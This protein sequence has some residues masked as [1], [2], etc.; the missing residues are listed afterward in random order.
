MIIQLDNPSI[1]EDVRAW[2]QQQQ[3]ARLHRLRVRWNSVNRG[4]AE[5]RNQ[6]LDEAAGC[7]FAVFFDDDVCPQ[8]GCLD[9]YVEAFKQYPDEAGYAGPTFLPRQPHRLLP[10]S[11]HMSDVSF[12]WDAPVIQASSEN[13]YVPWAVTANVAFKYTS[14]RFRAGFFP[15][16][17]EQNCA[18]CRTS[19]GQKDC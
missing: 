9:A 2:L 19:H 1:R 8:P 7:D 4:A 13:P 15:K 11:I 14:C 5:A 17:G 3:Q 10:T 6:L 16:T 12:F 18:T